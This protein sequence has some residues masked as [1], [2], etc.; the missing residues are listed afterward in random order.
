MFK[1]FL[2]SMFSPFVLKPLL[3][4]QIH[5]PT[6]ALC[7]QTLQFVEGEATVSGLNDGDE[8]GNENVGNVPASV[9][10]RSNKKGKAGTR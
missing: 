5:F 4:L 6:Q 9:C 1:I 3:P 8:V 2:L 7:C 10:S